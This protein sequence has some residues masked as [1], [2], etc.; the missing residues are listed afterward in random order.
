[1]KEDPGGQDRLAAQMTREEG[2]S[3]FRQL[4]KTGGACADIQTDLWKEK[5]S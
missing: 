2:A 4:V 3:G 5:K 1:M